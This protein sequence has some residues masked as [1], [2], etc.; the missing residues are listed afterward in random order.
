MIQVWEGMLVTIG[1]KLQFIVKLH[2]FKGAMNF[3][4]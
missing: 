3:S 1:I 2:L 4:E